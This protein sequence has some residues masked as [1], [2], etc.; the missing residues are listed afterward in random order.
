MI[1]STRVGVRGT[2]GVV[3]RA[4]GQYGVCRRAIGLDVLGSRRNRPP[5]V[6]SVVD[7][8]PET[9]QHPLV[10]VVDKIRGLA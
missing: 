4:E 5:L 3:F 8:R 2:Y 1:G 9:L 10:L 6:P 7:G